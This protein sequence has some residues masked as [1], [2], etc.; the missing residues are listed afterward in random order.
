MYT[1][2]IIG[3]ISVLEDFIKNTLPDL[4][5]NEGYYVSLF[6]R[7]K[8]YKELTHIKSDKAQ[9]K[10]FT[11]NKE[12][13]IQKLKQLECPIGAYNQKHMIVPQ[14]A[15]AV[16]ITINPRNYI[17]AAHTSLI[18]L[19][20]L[21]ANKAEG[22]N[23]HQHVMSDIQK[24]CSRK[25]YVDFDYDTE[26]RPNSFLGKIYSTVPFGVTTI[27]KTRGGYHVLVDPLLLKTH[28]PDLIKTWYNS[29]K[30][31]GCDQCGDLMV[32]IPGCYQGGLDFITTII[33]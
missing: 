20:S 14:Q 13:L 18:T 8:Y 1:Y 32:P 21:I 2:K 19:S 4:Q 3:N 33:A 25:V 17:S 9:L 22:Y 23:P 12:N 6:A 27:I 29:M 24:S 26:E 10:R 16:Y 5:P 31:I 28:R 11:C 30:E 7:N 15:L